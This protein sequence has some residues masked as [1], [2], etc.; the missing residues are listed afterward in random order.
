MVIKIDSVKINHTSNREPLS[1]IQVKKS[2][3]LHVSAKAPRIEPTIEKK[4]DEYK[5]SRIR[6]CEMLGLSSDK[7]LVID[8]WQ[9]WGSD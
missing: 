6:E 9:M 4:Y 8:D 5:K 3:V 1:N 7:F 2:A